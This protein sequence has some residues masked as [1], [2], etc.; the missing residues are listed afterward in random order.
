M[1]EK[2]GHFVFGKPVLLTLCLGLTTPYSYSVLVLKFY[3]TFVI[4]CIE[5]WLRFEP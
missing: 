1:E 4:F 5:L 2:P 3:Q